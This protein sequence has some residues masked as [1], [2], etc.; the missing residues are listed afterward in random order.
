MSLL[1]FS[2]NFDTNRTFIWLF[3]ETWRTLFCTAEKLSFSGEVGLIPESL[4]LASLS[5][6]QYI[7]PFC[8]E[9][10]LHSSSFFSFFSHVMLY[11]LSF[12]PTSS[13]FYPALP[14]LKASL[15]S[16][17]LSRPSSSPYPSSFLYSLSFTSFPSSPSSLS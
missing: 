14:F 12:P 3:R 11:P 8:S 16:L 9:L 17:C 7:P 15:H 6:T 13:S 1:G 5:P 10:L 2:V 4:P